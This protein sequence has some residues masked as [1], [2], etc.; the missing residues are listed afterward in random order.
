M[1]SPTIPAVRSAHS[2]TG[3]ARPTSTAEL[4]ARLEPYPQL[5]AQFETM[6]DEME[7]RAGALNTGDQAE[8]AIVERMRQM[9][10]QVLTQWTEQRQ[11]SV[12]PEC[13]SGLRQGGKK[14]SAG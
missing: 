10:R 2:P 8:D 6:L 11:D 13:T 4:I 14:K 1:N 3:P 7:N 9:G 12:Q 5:R